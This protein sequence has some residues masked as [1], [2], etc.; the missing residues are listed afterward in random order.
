METHEDLCLQPLGAEVCVCADIRARRGSDNPW[1]DIMTTMQ[2]E[3]DEHARE[4]ENTLGAK[5]VES[6]S[7]GHSRECARWIWAD[8]DLPCDC[9]KDTNTIAGELV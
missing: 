4:H 6:E 8:R 2:M 7:L 1:G 3:H 9:G 5:R